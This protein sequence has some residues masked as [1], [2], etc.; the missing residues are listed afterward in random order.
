M[1]PQD[2]NQPSVKRIRLPSGRS[3]EVVRLADSP[4]EARMLHVCPL[5]ESD[6]VQPLDWSEVDD[7]RWHL[8]LECPNCSWSEQGVYSR[9]QVDQLEDRLDDGLCD[10]I[11]DLQKLVRANMT[12]EIDR[13]VAAL[14]ADLI[15]PEDF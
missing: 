8:T 13:F 15:L 1:T 14:W 7:T 4:P 11:A 12:D 10:M 6:L 3:V 2:P 9:D 5:C